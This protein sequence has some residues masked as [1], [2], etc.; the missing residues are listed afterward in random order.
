MMRRKIIMGLLSLSGMIFL[1]SSCNNSDKKQ[2]TTVTTTPKPAEKTI[3]KNT[4]LRNWFQNP[5]LIQ[6][7]QRMKKKDSQFSVS[8]F[9]KAQEEPLQEQ[10]GKSFSEEEWKSFQPYFVFSPDHTL[11][12]DLYSYGNVS[13]KKSGDP[14]ELEGGD[15]D[16]EVSLVNVKNR[17]KT[18]LL[19]A[20]PGTTFQQAAWIGDSVILITGIS[21]ANAEN[22]MKP[23]LW[24]IDLKEQTLNP[25]EYQDKSNAQMQ[26]SK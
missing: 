5:N 4:E 20:G 10:P 17:T 16:S 15:P 19:F 8:H 1:F 21:D 23:V 11:A 9:S 2:E 7:S 6:W 22:E 24:K 3:D 25:Y 12:I 18:R 26:N 14:T 13:G